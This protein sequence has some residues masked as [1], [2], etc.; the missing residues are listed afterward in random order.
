MNIYYVYAYISKSGNPYYVGKG[1][2]SRAFD[3]HYNI[4]RPKCQSKILILES[5]LTEIGAFALERRLIRL[6]GR[7]DIGTGILMNRTD[8]GEGV[9]GYKHKKSSIQKMRTAKLGK[10]HTEKTRIKMSKSHAGIYHTEETISKMRKPKSPDHAAKC[11][12]HRK[13]SFHQ[14]ES[15]EKMRTAAANRPER[16]CP[17]CGKTGKAGAMTRYHFNNCKY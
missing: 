8:G 4:K 6:Y 15:K 3:P 11:G 9:A 7:K 10:A 14:Q 5:N 2:G 1:K 12:L 17:H 13:G 16:T